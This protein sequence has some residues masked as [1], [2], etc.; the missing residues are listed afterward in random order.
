[1]YPAALR[2]KKRNLLLIEKQQ[3]RARSASAREKRRKAR[4]NEQMA[5]ETAI[6]DTEY[7]RSYPCYRNTEYATS[8]RDP[9]KQKSY[10]LS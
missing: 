10:F 3:E 1:M 4:F 7:R 6:W 8:E 2:A 5:R 9:R